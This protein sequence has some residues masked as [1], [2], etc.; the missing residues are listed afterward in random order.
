MKR[1]KKLFALL[2]TVVSALSL[3]QPAM[4]AGI[5]YMPDVGAEMS[6]ASYWGALRQSAQELIL[7]P[8]EIQAFN[9]DTELASGTMVMDL[10]SAAETFD[11]LWV[12][13][14]RAER[15]EELKK[16]LSQPVRVVPMDLTKNECLEA[17]KALLAAEQPEVELLI[18][19]SLS[20]NI[21][22][23]S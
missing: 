21:N 19:C 7:T 9:K 20:V 15:L 16:E 12:I 18:N 10:R 22:A 3:A 4:A 8:E 2:L 13:A 23:V 14:R 1:G 17:Y 11:E 5:T 6:D